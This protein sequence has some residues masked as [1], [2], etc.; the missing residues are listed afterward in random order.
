MKNVAERAGFEPA[1]RYKRTLAFQASAL[2]LSATSPTIFNCTSERVDSVHPAPRPA[3]ASASLQRPKS[4]PAILLATQPLL[5][6]FSNH[7]S[8]GGMIRRLWRLTPQGG[9]SLTSFAARLSAG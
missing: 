5:P 2:S 7:T 1:V 9:R 6:L 3:G 8:E 4:I